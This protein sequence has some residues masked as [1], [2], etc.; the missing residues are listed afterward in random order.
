MQS[1]YLQISRQIERQPRYCYVAL[2]RVTLVNYS[3]M[4]RIIVAGILLKLG[5]H[6]ELVR[7]DA[8]EER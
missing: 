8:A 6:R 2:P 3:G 5:H 1:R 7:D 4:A